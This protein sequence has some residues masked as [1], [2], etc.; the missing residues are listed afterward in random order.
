MTEGREAVKPNR[1]PLQ[2]CATA[3]AMLVG[4]TAYEAAKQFVFPRLSLWQSHLVTIV[5][6]SVCATVIAAMVLV[7]HHRLTDRVIRAST[8]SDHL[9]IELEA[10]VAQLTHS[11][12][13]IR[14]LSGLLPICSACKKIR[15]NDGCWTPIEAY[16][17]KRSDVDFS[18]G[19]CPECGKKL[20]PED[21]DL[22]SD[23][24]AL[25]ETRSASERS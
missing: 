11:L 14:T 18:H 24:L 5:F 7:K 19:I 10:T 9:R 17:R 6:S 13:T 22:F 4:M 23:A 16:I 2:L 12:S 20:Y 15:D 3:T 21:A 25:P 1:L 8:E